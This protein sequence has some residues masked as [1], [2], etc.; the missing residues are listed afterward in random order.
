M[1]LGGDRVHFNPGSAALRIYDPKERRARDARHG[2]PRE[3]R[4]PHRRA[5]GYAAQSTGLIAG[6]VPQEI[7]DRY[8]LFIALQHSAK[9][10]VTGTFRVDA[11]QVDARDALG[12]RRGRRE[13]PR[14]AD[15][16][17]RLLPLAPAQVERPHRAGAHRLR[18]DG[19]RRRAHLD[20]AHRGHLAGHARRRRRAALRRVA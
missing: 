8:R 16:D 3:V 2:R 7:Q 14:E 18:A 19:H 1:D 6:D 12:G 11:L 17:L 20:A 13:A 10:V 4:H 5:P 9:P 15:G